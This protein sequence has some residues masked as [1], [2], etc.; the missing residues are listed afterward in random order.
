MVSMYDEW[1]IGFH[2]I[3]NDYRVRIEYMAVFING[4]CGRWCEFLF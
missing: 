4:L 2:I 1:D 3:D